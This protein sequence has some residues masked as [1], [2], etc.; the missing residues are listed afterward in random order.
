MDIRDR[1]KWIACNIFLICFLFWL[2]TRYSYLGMYNSD[3]CSQLLR[4]REM[5]RGDFFLKNWYGAT[6]PALT[7]N[8]LTGILG[9]MIG[10]ISSKTVLVSGVILYM[11]ITMSSIWLSTNCADNLKEKMIRAFI[12]VSVVGIPAYRYF[13]EFIRS[14]SHLEAYIYM[15]LLLLVLDDKRKKY[16]YLM[17][18]F[19]LIFVLLGDSIVLYEFVLPVYAAILVKILYENEQMHDELQ[20]AFVTGISLV[21]V[22]VLNKVFSFLGWW[23]TYESGVSTF[24][25]FENM[26]PN[27]MTTLHVYLEYFNASFFSLQIGSLEA[28]KSM[29]GMAFFCIEV[30]MLII[31]VKKYCFL[32]FADQIMLWSIGI[33]T[34]AYMFSN[35]CKGE[36]TGRYLLMCVINIGILTARNYTLLKDSIIIRASRHLKQYFVPVFMMMVCFLLYA[37]SFQLL[38][39]PIEQE[40]DFIARILIE[41]DLKCGYASYWNSLSTTVAT[42]GDVRVIAV[43]IN[44][45][46]S[47]LE[48]FKWN[49]EYDWFEEKAYFVIASKDDSGLDYNDVINILGNSDTLFETKSNYILVYNNAI[50]NKLLY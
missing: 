6:V 1:K 40:E 3:T 14:V 28:V 33:M 19:L 15:I 24:L 5:F 4:A 37:K 50:S 41:N 20:L 12:A 47:M 43:N 21:V 49:A 34:F 36:D 27:F 9:Y 25:D 7:T 8:L 35:M 29:I 44:R 30:W 42:N 31:L 39:E 17:Y 2:Y 46:K 38:T 22:I 48:A 16:S 18:F 26:I 10:G 11:L 32:P 23:G 13:G 45:D